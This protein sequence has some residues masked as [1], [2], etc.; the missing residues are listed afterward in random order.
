MLIA[1]NTKS[2]SH[3]CLVLAMVIESRLWNWHES[4]K[5]VFQKNTLK[6]LEDYD[7]AGRWSKGLYERNN[8]PRD[9]NSRPLL[10]WGKVDDI[11]LN[12]MGTYPTLGSR[13]VNLQFILPFTLVV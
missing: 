5:A 4:G 6:F 10:L 1:Y 2:K 7:A 13:S 3:A 9:Q 11:V 8:C 12:H